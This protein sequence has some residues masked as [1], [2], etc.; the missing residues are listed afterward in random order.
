M[1]H[2]EIHQI[3][4]DISTEQGWNE[5]SQIVHL[6]GFIIW[7]RRNGPLHKLTQSEMDVK[8]RAYLQNQADDENEG[9]EAVCEKCGDRREA[10]SIL[11]ICENCKIEAAST[12]WKCP[13]CGTTQV[14]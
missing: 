7:I 3:L 4:V 9:V 12:D 8:F 5:E 6:C 2:N 14:I 1:I 10:D 13:K 11:N